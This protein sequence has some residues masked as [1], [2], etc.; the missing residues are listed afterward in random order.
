MYSEN[1]V[2]KIITN[3]DMKN[4]WKVKTIKIRI[5]IFLGETLKVVKFNNKEILGKLFK[6][7]N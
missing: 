2:L 3:K 7:N 6:S 5:L 4:Y 1:I